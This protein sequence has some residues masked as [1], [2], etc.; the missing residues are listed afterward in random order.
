V[1]HI[2]AAAWNYSPV[3]IKKAPQY[4][5]LQ[6]IQPHTSGLIVLEVL[7]RLTAITL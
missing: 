7:V 3:K 1:P 6:A 5:Y 2:L 4:H